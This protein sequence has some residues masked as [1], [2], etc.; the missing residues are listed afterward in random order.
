MKPKNSNPSLTDTDLENAPPASPLPPPPPPKVSDAAPPARATVILARAPAGPAAETPAAGAAAAPTA[1]AEAG[2]ARKDQTR[3]PRCGAYGCP[4]SGGS[5]ENREYTLR[6][7][8][9]AACKHRFKTRQR[10]G[11]SREDVIG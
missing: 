4:A 8:E 9:C 1:A 3:C 6:Y 7:R 10:R 2:P 5:R 11:M